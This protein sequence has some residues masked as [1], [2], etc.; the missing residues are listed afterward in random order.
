MSSVWSGSFSLYFG[1]WTEQCSDMMTEFG[2]SL[3]CR[4]LEHCF[5]PSVTMNLTYK[6]TKISLGLRAE[7]ASRSNPAPCGTLKT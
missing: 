4:L 5:P 6:R 3:G 2:T 1:F 7:L